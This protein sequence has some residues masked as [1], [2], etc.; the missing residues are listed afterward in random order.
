LTAQAASNFTKPAPPFAMKS[1]FLLIVAFG[2][3]F[4]PLSAPRG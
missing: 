1:H 2:V 4:Y 3:T